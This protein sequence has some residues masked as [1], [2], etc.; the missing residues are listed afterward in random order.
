[1]ILVIVT[2]IVPLSDRKQS[3]LRKGRG[4]LKSLIQRLAVG[5]LLVAARGMYVWAFTS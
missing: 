3:V 5:L 2:A 1:M 4:M